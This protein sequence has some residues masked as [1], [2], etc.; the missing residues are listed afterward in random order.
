M[1]KFMIISLGIFGFSLFWFTGTW[2]SI[3]H[4]T[5]DTSVSWDCNNL[6]ETRY[7]MNKTIFPPTQ[8]NKEISDMEKKLGC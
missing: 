5:L 1:N 7:V 3:S 4:A 6:N 2:Y 8:L